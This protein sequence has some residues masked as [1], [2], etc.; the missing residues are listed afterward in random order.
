MSDFYFF[1][2]PGVLDAQAATQAYGP[3]P[4]N[5]FTQY[6]LTSMHSASGTAPAYAVCD[7]FL[8]VQEQASGLLNLILIPN[9]QPDNRMPAVRFFIYR[10]VE[11]TSLIDN[12]FIADRNLNDVTGLLWDIHDEI[13]SWAIEVEGTGEVYDTGSEY[14]DGPSADILGTEFQTFPGTQNLSEILFRIGSAY[15]APIVKAGWHIGDFVGNPQTGAS[16]F[17]FEVVF[18]NDEGTPTFDDARADE[19]I[20][21]VADFSTGPTE[22]DE[23]AHWTAKEE[24]LNYI[25]PAAYFGSFWAYGLKI[26]GDT[27]PET[28]KGIELFGT[29]ITNFYNKNILYLDIRNDVGGSFNYFRNFS[30]TVRLWFG[31]DQAYQQ[32]FDYYANWP[33][34]A[35]DMNSVPFQGPAQDWSNQ[36][37]TRIELGLDDGSIAEGLIFH[38]RAITAYSPADN[39][40]DYF[41]GYLLDAA[42]GD[43]FEYISQ[44]TGYEAALPLFVPFANSYP[45]NTDP[46][47]GET[48]GSSPPT[49]VGG[50]SVCTYF[51]ILYLR[52]RYTYGPVRKQPDNNNELFGQNFL[53]NLFMPVNLDVPLP[54]FAETEEVETRSY[55]SEREIFVDMVPFRDIAYIGR[56]GIAIDEENVTLFCFPTV[57]FDPDWKGF[58]ISPT[59]VGRESDEADYL[60]SVSLL[61][62][63]LEV[64]KREFTSDEFAVVPYV[65]LERKLGFRHALNAVNP[66]EWVSITISKAQ[67]QSLQ[68]LA[69]GANFAPWSQV[70]LGV[71]YLKRG[72]TNNQKAKLEA[73][74]LLRGLEVKNDQ[75]VGMLEVSTNVIIYARYE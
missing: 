56:Q 62:K 26:A 65:S 7:G 39:E 75:S 18:A 1:T 17:G 63:N 36:Y 49:G 61:E 10:G 66:D 59:Q 23:F 27:E 3:V 28:L 43:Q 35:V 55:V 51:R 44:D 31:L 11:K 15:Q 58:N 68:T 71:E 60:Y 47:T 54:G 9:A 41:L 16:G 52:K 14:G 22:A 69:A 57:K 8:L 72:Y 73:K 38:S 64:A 37:S 48:G 24:I 30:N 2:D 32:D 33:I 46:S 53:D 67:F 19:N 4:G 42:G 6:R 74:L 21:T 29:V 34:L 12:A 20:L 13:L 50:A 25:D 40:D 5:E 70:Y 45:I